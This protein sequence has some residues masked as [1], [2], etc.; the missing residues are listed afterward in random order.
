MRINLSA[1]KLSWVAGCVAL[2]A[3]PAV[4]ALGD[5]PDV[6]TLPDYAVV[7]PMV[8][9]Q[10]PVASMP[11]PVSV[12]RF[13]PRVDVEARNL[14]EAQADVTIR[15]GIFE[16]SGFKVGAVSLYDPQTGHY[17]AEIPIAPAMLGPPSILTGAANALAGFNANVGTVAYAWRPI[18]SRGEATVAAGDFGYNRQSVY[19]GLVLPGSWAGEQAA[20]DVEW[21]RSESDGSVPFGDHNFQRL[22]GRV[23]LRGA[24]SQTDIFA[25]YQHKFF[26]WPNLYTPFGFDETEDL[27]T[28]LV[29]ANHRWWDAAG[30]HFEIGAFYRRNR[31]DYEFDRFVPGLFNPYQHTTWVRG[32]ALDGFQNLDGFA[33][34]YSAQFMHD[35]I[36][37]TSLVF[38]PFNNRSYLKLAA[39]PEKTFVLPDGSLTLRGGLT[40]DDSD[41]DKSALSPLFSAEW[42]AKAGPKAYLEYAET[43]QLPTYTALKSSPTAGLFLGNQGLGRETSR[44]L[45]L[46]LKNKAGG[47]ELEASVFYRWDDALVDWTYQFGSPSARKANAV[48][49]GTAGIELVASHRTKHFDLV[50]GYTFLHK[51]AD[52]GNATVDASFYALNFPK[53]RL[54]AALIWRLGAGFEIRSDNE[55]RVQEPNALR[56]AGGDEAVISSLGIYYLPPGMRGWEFSVQ[57][58]NLWD[59]DFQDVPSVPAAGRQVAGSVTKRW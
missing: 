9:N 48:D 21:S 27:Q 33:L 26:G 43:S 3:A 46:G 32:G 34:N 11:M 42:Q 17:F 51:N 30:D 31:D 19:Q 20:A 35:D 2:T 56:T 45:E 41:R 12:L 5:E 22:D 57:A 29:T 8:A 25:G 44:N 4:V 53:Q 50:L 39:A 15:G 58:D 14:P 23:Q 36:H 1:A 37:S 47:W 13:E 38:G 16:N 28:V 55:F 52:Y 18:E 49:I 24:N 40:Y 10:E 7:S 54:T 59:S 6:T